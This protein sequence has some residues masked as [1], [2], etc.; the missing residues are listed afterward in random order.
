M[1]HMINC[2]IK[3][4]GD[5]LWLIQSCVKQK[6][7]LFGRQLKEE[8]C[9][10]MSKL[11]KQVKMCSVEHLFHLNCLCC[12]EFGVKFYFNYSSS[13]IN[14]NHKLDIVLLSLRAIVSVSLST[15]NF[16][17]TLQEHHGQ[18]VYTINQNLLKRF[19]ININTI[20]ENDKLLALKY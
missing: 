18:I 2:A 3:D 15:R 14:K 11:L 16:T 10:T 4:L 6:E 20:S 5:S 13:S 8:T 17:K 7:N 1:V 19:Y 12:L 9:C